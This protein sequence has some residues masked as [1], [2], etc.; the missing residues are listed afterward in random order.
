MHIK[1]L[2]TVDFNDQS[3]EL[4]M[5]GTPQILLR[6]GNAINSIESQLKFGIQIKQLQQQ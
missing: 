2:I 3:A 6:R 5:Y 1:K 4:Y